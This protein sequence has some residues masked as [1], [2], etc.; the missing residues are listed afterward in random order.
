MVPA[1]LKAGDPLL[2]PERIARATGGEV[3]AGG[4]AAAGVSVDSRRIQPGE[5]FVALAGPRHDGHDHIAEAVAAGAAGLLV[6]RRPAALPAGVFVVRVRDTGRALLALAADRRRALALRAVAVTGT[7]GKTTTKDI[8]A[9]LLAKHRRTVA[10]AASYNNRV[11][12]PLTLFACGPR[13]EVAVLELGTNRPGEIAELAAAADPDVGV[14]TLV[15]RGH[16]EGLGSLAGVLAEKAALPRA[17]RP[18]GTCVLPADDPALPRLE[19]AAAGRRVLRFGLRPGAELGA[20]GLRAEAAGTAATI[21]DRSFGR[22]ERARVLL[23]L[24]GAH[25]LRNLLAAL[26]AGR[27]LGL[28]LAELIAGVPALR[29]PPR[30]LEAKHAP[31]GWTVLDDSYNA[32]PE[33][34]AAALAVLDVWPGARRRILVLG[35]MCELGA[36]AA[37]LHREAGRSLAGRVDALFALGPLA[38]EAAA[39]FERAAPGARIERAADAAALCAALR[40]ELAPGDLVLVKASRRMALDRVADA[41]LAPSGSRARPPRCS[42]SSSNT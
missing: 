19:R 40:T 36:G 41:L 23:P 29:P 39:A 24:F 22:E 32:N 37:A 4:R 16:L 6:A 15:G 10:A 17:V 2:A 8:L 12:L 18:G 42:T 1:E 31:G 14:V 13:T 9:A 7:C 21:V 26:A 34:L 30:R 3:L 33:S 20:E 27:A 28:E 5:L 35:D 38:A 25:N 11:G